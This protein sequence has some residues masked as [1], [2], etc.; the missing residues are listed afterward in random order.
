MCGNKLLT[1]VMFVFFM[2]TLVS[3]LDRH[4][5]IRVPPVGADSVVTYRHEYDAASQ[6]SSLVFSEVVDGELTDI[7]SIIYS[8]SSAIKTA[9]AG[10]VIFFLRYPKNHSDER[11]LWRYDTKR[12]VIEYLTNV[13]GFYA[14]SEDGTIVAYI[15]FRGY[16][17]PNTDVEFYDI[18]KDSVLKVFNGE[19]EI[20][21]RYAVLDK[22]EDFAAYV[23]FDAKAQT[24][25]ITLDDWN[26]GGPK[27]FSVDVTM[28]EL[29]GE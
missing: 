11:E 15:I 2:P 23:E 29:R 8:G 25:I 6:E 22:Y 17:I 20:H 19:E 4:Q 10:Q 5:T 9:N 26:E 18:Q 14:V 12:G 27:T 24:F 16:T 21:K 28:A 7:V 13:T 1:F 3:G